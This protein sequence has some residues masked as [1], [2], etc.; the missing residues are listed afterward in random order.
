MNKTELIE[1][2]ASKCDISKT[3][4]GEAL[5]GFMEI[6]TE[7]LSAGDSIS[8]I[9]F[10]NF[11]VSDRAARTGRNPQTG[12][13]LKIPASKVAKFSPGA[14]L[15]EAVNAGKKKKKK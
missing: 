15:K 11:S 4:A 10:G 9:G 8:L 14:K 3:A 2:L 7:T 1:A 12:A 5:D 13:E 6:V